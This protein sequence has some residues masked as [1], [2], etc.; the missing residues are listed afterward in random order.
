MTPVRQDGVAL[1]AVVLMLAVVGALALAMSREGAMSARSAGDDYD[2]AVARSLADGALNL[3]RWRGQRAGCRVIQ[4]LPAT[5]LAGAGTMSA[6]VSSSGSSTLNVTAKGQTPSGASVTLV[7]DKVEVR[8]LTKPTVITVSTTEADS[9]WLSGAAPD[10]LQGGAAFLELGQG[11]A[12]ILVRFKLA[13]VPP[14]SSIISAQLTL[15]QFQSS[16]F[17]GS[18]SV[19][20]VK[21]SWNQQGASWNAALSGT[22]WERAGGD[23]SAGAIARQTVGANGS[24]TWDVTALVDG[25]FNGLYSNYGFAL[26]ADGP[27]QQARFHSFTGAAGSR[28]TL[29]VN[30]VPSC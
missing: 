29:V 17:S 30:Y 6:V 7:R 2:A 11:N 8:D 4:D 3:A 14:D 25:W 1:L 9:T 12:N 18:V 20:R 21:N 27:I 5:P 10:A 22:P 19:R 13:D 26:I 28:P 24:Y 15:T 23:Y 16:P